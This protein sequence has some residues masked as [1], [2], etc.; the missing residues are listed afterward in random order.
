M[1]KKYQKNIHRSFQPENVDNPVDNVDKL[2]AKQRFPYFYNVSGT[3]S[4]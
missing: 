4:Y 2:F 1:L 3:H